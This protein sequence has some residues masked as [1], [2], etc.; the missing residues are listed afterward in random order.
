MF[1]SATA[2]EKTSVAK[3]SI[4]SGKTFLKR[5]FKTDISFWSFFDV[6]KNV[7]IYFLVL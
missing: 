1:V 3:L 6:V 5:V 2:F 4:L 7:F